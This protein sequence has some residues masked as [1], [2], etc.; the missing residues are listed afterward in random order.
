MRDFR[1]GAPAF[2]R[3]FLRGRSLVA[4]CA[5]AI[6]AACAMT[7]APVARAQDDPPAKLAWKPPF[8]FQPVPGISATPPCDLDAVL[9]SA[10]HRAQVLLDNLQNFDA[11][12]RVRFEDTDARRIFRAT[13][14]RCA[15]Q[16]LSFLNSRNS[17]RISRKFLTRTTRRLFAK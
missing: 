2:V 12:E 16:S 10:G 11:H 7:L 1:S 17:G 15:G 13:A 9:E 3:G 5:V 6:A 4:L 14:F 8:A